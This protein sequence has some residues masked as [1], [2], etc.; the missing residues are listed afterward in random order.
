[1]D[2]LLL[3]KAR[4]KFL[5]TSLASAL[6]RIVSS[7]LNKGYALTHGCQ[8]QI[9]IEKDGTMFSPY[10]CK[11]RWC[12]SCASINMATMINKYHDNLQR[13]DL[14]FVTLTQP[15][16]IDLDLPDTINT[17][18]K[19]WRQIADLAR[20]KGIKFN[21]L[22]KLE[23]KMAN[24][25]KYHPHF[26]VLIEGESAAKW[27]IT[28][29]LKRSPKSSPLAQHRDKVSDYNSALVELMKY[30][31]KLT[32]AEDSSNEL[33]L[34]TPYQM[35]TI[36]TALHRR[37]IYQPFG[38]VNAVDESEMDITTEQVRKAAGL[39]EW[40]GCDWYHIEFGHALSGWNPEGLEVQLYKHLNKHQRQKF[41]DAK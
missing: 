38:D 28:Q 29:W 34:A 6:V 20:K 31:S 32:C 18:I 16:V 27:L 14:Q 11:R 26:H 36:F 4:K 40:L 13:D 23:C 25:G 12:M 3:K 21:G 30:A 7:P 1:M 17:M 19:R 37:R 24:R 15:T 35:D 2:N 33:I 39:Y 41:N 8:S 10:Y 5:S 9:Y 22:R